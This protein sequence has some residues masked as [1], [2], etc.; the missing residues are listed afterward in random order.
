MCVLTGLVAQ[1]LEQGTHNPL[2]VGSKPTRPTKSKPRKI[3]VIYAV[4]LFSG[5]LKLGWQHIMLNMYHRPIFF[6]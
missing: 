1:G 3:N 6:E 5:C 4:V 2:V